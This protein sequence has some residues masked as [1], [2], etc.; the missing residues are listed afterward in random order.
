MYPFNALTK[1]RFIKRL[2]RFV[3]LLKMEQTGEQ[4]E[5]HLP[6]PGRLKELLVPDAVVWASYSNNPYRKTAWTAMLCEAENGTLVSLKTTIANTIV[7]K[8]FMSQSLA[9]FEN[10]HLEKREYSV[11]N[12]RF[13]FLLTN[14]AGTKLLVEVKSVTLGREEKGFFPD[15]VTKRGT[16]HVK[17]LTELAHTGIYQSCILFVAQREDISS[18]S[19]EVDIDPVFAKAMEE[20][21]DGGVQVLAVST[22]ISTEKI[23]LSSFIPVFV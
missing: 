6:D 15:A 10:W 12:S 2:N 19:M 16:K 20:A 7:E 14:E 8:A 3:L 9:P 5:A 4:I 18:V 21:V 1:T 13:D 23:E 17:E 11:G 22:V